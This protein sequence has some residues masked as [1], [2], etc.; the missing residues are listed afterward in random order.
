MLGYGDPEANNTLPSV[1]L[2]ASENESS[3][4]EVGLDKGKMMGVVFKAAIRRTTGSGNAPNV[5][6]RPTRAVGLTCSITSARDPN[7]VVV[8]FRMKYFL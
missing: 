1:Q 3:H 2:R 8:S 6:D 4:F 7:S 5:V